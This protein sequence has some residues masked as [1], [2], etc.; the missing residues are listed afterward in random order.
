MNNII[1]EFMVQGSE[2]EPYKVVFKKNSANLKATCS[3]R[4]GMMGQM[5]K[6]RL[7]IMGGDNSAIVSDNGEKVIEVVLLLVGSQAGEA[8]ANVKSLESEKKLIDERIKK[9][10][11]ALVKALGG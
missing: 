7:M 1:H 9:A 6:H 3:C 5:C 10:K 11:K 8:F 2:P 4:A